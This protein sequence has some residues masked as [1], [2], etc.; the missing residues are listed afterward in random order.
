M[1]TS[2][3]NNE[4]KEDFYNITGGWDWKGVPLIE[5]YEVKKADPALEPNSWCI[6]FF[7]D[8]E[9]GTYNVKRVDVKDS[10]IYLLCGKVDEKNDSTLVNLRN[11]PTGWFVIDTKQKKEEG[12]TTEVEFNAF[13]RNNKYPVPELLD[14]DSLSETLSH[15]K[16]LPWQFK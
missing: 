9:L 4:K 10:I 15:G 5:P 2:R 16:K 13:I 12:F 6:D 11:V 1:N 14:L 8:H 7:S 3:N